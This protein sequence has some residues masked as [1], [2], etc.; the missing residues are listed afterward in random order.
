MTGEQAELENALAVIGHVDPPAP[1]VLREARE[2][3]WSAVAGEVPA[4]GDARGI[5]AR[6]M[7]QSQQI[8][9]RRTDRDS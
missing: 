6:G 7:D 2:V 9:R 1:R 4:A 3:L 5:R 8:V